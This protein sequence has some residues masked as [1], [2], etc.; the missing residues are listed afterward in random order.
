MHSSKKRVHRNHSTHKQTP[1]GILTNRCSE[2]M[3]Q[4]YKGT[5]PPRLSDV[6]QFLNCASGAIQFNNTIYNAVDSCGHWNY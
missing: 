4:V 1:S 3:Q 6:K 5:F 2:N